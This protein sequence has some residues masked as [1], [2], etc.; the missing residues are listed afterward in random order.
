M[1][2]AIATATVVKPLT[3]MTARNSDAVETGAGTGAVP[4][5]GAAAGQS[6]PLSEPLFGRYT[7]SAYRYDADASRLVILFR[8]P[9]DGATLD[10]IPTEAALRQYREAQKG[11]KGGKASLELVVGDSDGQGQQN[12]AGQSGASQTHRSASGTGVGRASVSQGTSAP[13]PPVV[14]STP[15]TARAAP[16]A[17][18]GSG[19]VNVVI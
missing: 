15:M 18:S 4:T 13:T 17:S 14:V 8:N 16:A 19:H 2:V 7:K 5:K 9:E 11:R 1:N 3:V 6:D 12:G 10:Q